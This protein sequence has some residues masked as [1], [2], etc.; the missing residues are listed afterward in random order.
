MLG[1]TESTGLTDPTPGPFLVFWCFCR[2]HLVLDVD[3]EWI[4]FI[5]CSVF[6]EVYNSWRPASQLYL[7]LR[8]PQAFAVHGRYCQRHSLAARP[9]ASVRAALEAIR[10]IELC[11]I[12]R[13]VLLTLASWLAILGQ[14]VRLLLSRL[15]G[16]TVF[17]DRFTNGIAFPDLQFMISGGLAA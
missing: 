3:H 2:R 10:R 13:L 14:L 5:A 6:L 12:E 17:V 9:V 4:I 15:L 16:C 7:L 8:V 1:R 11:L